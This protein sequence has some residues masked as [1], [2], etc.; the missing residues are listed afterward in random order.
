MGRHQNQCLLILFTMAPR[1]Q[2]HLI[3]SRNTSG[4]QIAVRLQFDHFYYVCCCRLY[5]MFVMVEGVKDELKAMR[6]GLTSII[7]P[8]I[9]EGLTAEVHYFSPCLSP[10][11]PPLS[12]PPSLPLSLFLSLPLLLP[13]PLPLPLSLSLSLS[14]SLLLPLPL[15]PSL[16]LTPS[17]SLYYLLISLSSQDFQLLLAGDSANIS[18][19]RLK[20]VIKFNHTHGRP[21]HICERFEK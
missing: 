13:L 5:S 17:L 18:L 8:E 7:P 19:S 12:L 1:S 9:L 21:S 15:P 2:S 16:S 14:L 11:L 4:E 10:S 3:V 20:S 6:D